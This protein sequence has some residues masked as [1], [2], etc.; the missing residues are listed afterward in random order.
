MAFSSA[1]SVWW[2]SGGN[3]GKRK[4][5][6]QRDQKG[7]WWRKKKRWKKRKWR[8]LYTYSELMVSGRWRERDALGFE[9]GLQ[10][11]LTVYLQP[12][13]MLSHPWT[14]FFA[15]HWWLIFSS[16]TLNWAVFLVYPGPG[17]SL[18]YKNSFTANS[19]WEKDFQFGIWS[20]LKPGPT[21]I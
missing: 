20:S 6:S 11:T 16:S 18:N 17:Y 2:P 12:F 14:A 15:L 9:I 4:R 21:R 7:W 5:T 1:C 13:E 10:R 19:S 3:N 8:V